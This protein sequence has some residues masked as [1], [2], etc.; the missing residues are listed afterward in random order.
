MS[1]AFIVRRGG[2]AA[3]FAVISVTYPEGSTCTCTNGT[4]TLKAKDTSG[5]FL[6]MIPQEG[7]WIATATDGV[8]TVSRAVTITARGQSEFLH[9]R[10]PLY[11]YRRGDQCPLITGGWKGANEFTSSTAAGSFR[12]TNEGSYQYL[13]VV[14]VYNASYGAVT[15]ALV[16][17]TGYTTLHA[18]VST[19]SSVTARLAVGEVFP[20]TAS[21]V[22][23]KEVDGRGAE[24]VLDISQINGR[25]QPLIRYKTTVDI[26]MYIYEVWMD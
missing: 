19:Q 18:K 26:T 14:N 16:D 6:F 2:L 9:L 24:L 7:E 3:A 4:K 8:D 10:Y 13:A 17:M 15:T 1:E 22:S 20:G 12:A 25:N 11:L 23:E 5:R 21:G